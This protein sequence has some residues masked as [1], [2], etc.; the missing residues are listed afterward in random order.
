MFLSLTNSIRIFY[1]LSFSQYYG[2]VSIG[3]PQQEFKVVFDTGSSNLWVP[4]SECKTIACL[5][6]TRYDHSKSSTY[7]KNGTALNVKYG[8]GS[9]SGFISQDTV[10][11]GGIPVTKALFGEVTKEDGISFIASS[12]SGILGLACTLT[13]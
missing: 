13:P 3:T 5:L 2:P 8:S 9:I 6:H 12:F 11:L 4:S 10:T 1:F 7:V